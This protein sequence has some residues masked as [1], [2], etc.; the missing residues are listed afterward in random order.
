MSVRPLDREIEG[1][2]EAMYVSVSGNLDSIPL[3]E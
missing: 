2:I 3:I 1:W